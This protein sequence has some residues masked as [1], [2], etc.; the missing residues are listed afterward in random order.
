LFHVDA[1]NQPLEAKLNRAGATIQGHL[2]KQQMREWAQR[3]EAKYGMRVRAANAWN[4]AANSLTERV[5]SASA[6]TQSRLTAEEIERHKTIA[7]Q[8]CATKLAEDVAKLDD[9]NAV[10]RKRQLRQ[11]ICNFVQDKAPFLS[12]DEKIEQQSMSRFKGLVKSIVGS[13]TL[14]DVLDANAT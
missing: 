7:E 5:E 6:R 14:D 12:Y 9:T 2:S 13:K 8:L 11:R 4:Q 10:R 3:K 1:C